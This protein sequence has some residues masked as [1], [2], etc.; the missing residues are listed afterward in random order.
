M[1]PSSSP[2]APAAVRWGVLLLS[3]ILTFLWIW[4]LSFVLN[5]IGDIRGPDYQ[6]IVDRH[7]DA[8]LIDRS[9]ALQAEIRE[10]DVR[11]RRGQEIQSNLRSSMENARAMMNEM[12]E[13]H[14]LS[15]ERGVQPTDSQQEALA[16]SQQRF[17]EAQASFETA[18]ADIANSNQAKFE[19]SRELESLQQQ[20][21]ALKRPANEEYQRLRQ[22]HRFKVASFQLAF[23]VPIFLASGFLVM[24]KRESLFRP[25]L[26]SV[27]LAT[28]WKVGV[29]MFEHFPREFFKYIA[30][31]AAIGIVLTFLIWLLRRAAKPGIDLLI[32]RHREA[33]QRHRCPTCDFPIMRGPLRNAIWTGRKLKLPERSSN[34]EVETDEPYACPSCGSQLFETCT[35]C[36]H[37]RHSLLPFCEHCGNE[38]VMK[39]AVG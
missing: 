22:S 14:R 34:T 38:K 3:T 12:T 36:K 39:T 7:V 19:R 6:P 16:T 11:I 32:K 20:I 33:Y 29:V 26:V 28:F 27:L 18:N 1:K 13:L 17:I 21:E 30:I 25:I 35:E 23:I 4:L 10:I 24:K 15:L 2:A 31:T 5:D 9:E 37:Q 8:S